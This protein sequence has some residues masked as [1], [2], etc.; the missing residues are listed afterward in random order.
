MKKAL[1]LLLML[2]AMLM[3]APVEPNLAQQVAENFINADI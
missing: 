1:L 2:P 3:A